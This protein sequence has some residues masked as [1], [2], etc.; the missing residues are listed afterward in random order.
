MGTK[1]ERS[2]L[3]VVGGQEIK[4]L[5]DEVAVPDSSTMT[6]QVRN[7]RI[8]ASQ[9]NARPEDCLEMMSGLLMLQTALVRK[10]QGA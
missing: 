8:V 7:G 1:N 10:M 2:H 4:E 3:Y 5:S 9:I 6:L